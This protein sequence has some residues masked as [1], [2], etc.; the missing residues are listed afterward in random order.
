M[1]QDNVTKFS[2]FAKSANSL[3]NDNKLSERI[4]LPGGRLR[5]FVRGGVG[6]KD[7]NDFIGGNYASSVNIQTS[8]PQLLPNIQNMDVSMFFDAG[9]VWGVDYDSGLSDTNKIRSSIGLGVDWFTVVG[10][11]SVSF[12]HPISSVDTDKTESFKFNLG[13]TF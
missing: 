1:Y 7:G 9:N 3:T 2:F 12:S 8:V 4:Y 6:P 11:L 5:G 13:T 10:P